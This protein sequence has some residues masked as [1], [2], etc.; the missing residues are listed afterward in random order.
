V[1]EEF[2]ASGHNIY[3]SG[4]TLRQVYEVKANVIPG[5]SGGPLIEQDGDVM[6]VVFAESTT[7]SHVGYAL[8]M[9]KVASEI[10]QSTQ[11]EHQVS[12][13]QCAE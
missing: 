7:Y 5:N 2:E 13:G 10:N 8:A 3:G 12:T 11:N 9:P 4:Q 1:I 6:G